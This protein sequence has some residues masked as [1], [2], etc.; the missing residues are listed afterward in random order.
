[1]VV[2]LP[3]ILQLLSDGSGEPSAHILCFG[4]WILAVLV[5]D[6]AQTYFL[7]GRFHEYSNCLP[8]RHR[9]SGHLLP[10]NLHSQDQKNP[11]S[12]GADRSQY[13][14]IMG[15]LKWKG[16][17]AGGDYLFRPIVA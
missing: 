15:C 4:H 14:Q 2:P 16:E 5:Y 12:S 13:P 17:P 10:H 1:M 6:R 7:E 3:Y 11:E 8:D 9:F